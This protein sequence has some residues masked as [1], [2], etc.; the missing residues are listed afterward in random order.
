MNS[1]S[2]DARRPRGVSAV[3]V[4][5]NCRNHVLIILDGVVHVAAVCGLRQKELRDS[6]VIL[7][8]DGLI[9]QVSEQFERLAKRLRRAEIGDARADASRS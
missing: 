8:E 3:R 4:C 7:S 1:R 6:V 5:P 9:R 2:G